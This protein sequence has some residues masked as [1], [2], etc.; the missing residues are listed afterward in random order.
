MKFLSRRIIVMMLGLALLNPPSLFAQKEIDSLPYHFSDKISIIKFGT[1]SYYAAKFHGRKTSTGD[2]YRKEKFTAACN[3]L[4]LNTWVQVT[5]MRSG[6]QVI[7]KIND[8][9]HPKNKRL[10]D[11]SRAAAQKLGFIN[12]GTTKVKLELLNEIGEDKNED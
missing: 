6:R 10:I 1:A 4:P 5:D 2:I 9:L 8:R 11:L 7:V 12:K 3:V